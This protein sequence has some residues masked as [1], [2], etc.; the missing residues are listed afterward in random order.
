MYYN[1]VSRTILGGFTGQTG[2]L[3]ATIT[4]G[5][6]QNYTFT[7]TIPATYDVTKMKAIVLLIDNTQATKHIMNSTGSALPLGINP[8]SVIG[9]VDVFPNPMNENANININLISSQNVTVEVYDV[10]GALVS[11]EN[12]GVLSEGQHIVALNSKNLAN[13]MYFVKVTAGQAVETRKI[14]VTH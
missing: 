12:E 4:A 2:S 5:S 6:T 3:P 13:G 1:Y 9:S 14:N 10:T 11:T 8:L 7:Y